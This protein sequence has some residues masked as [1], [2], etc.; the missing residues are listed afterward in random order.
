MISV[1]E[2]RDT[3]GKIRKGIPDQTDSLVAFRALI[4]MLEGAG[5]DQHGYLYELIGPWPEVNQFCRE[6]GLD[7]G[8]DQ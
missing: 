1:T 6:E 2:L 8:D 5:W 7:E 3:W 4:E